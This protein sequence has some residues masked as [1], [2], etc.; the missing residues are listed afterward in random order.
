[1]KAGAWRE[2][3]LPRLR[4]LLAGALLSF[5]FAPFGAWPLAVLCPAWLMWEWQG[6]SARQSAALGFCFGAGTFGAGTWWL[7]ISIHGFGLAPIW[8]ALLLILA[9]V[10]FMAAGYALLGWAVGRLLPA[11]GPW[12]WY[13]GLPGLW[14]LLEWW[15]GWFISGFPWLSLGY[16]QTDTWLAG[17]APVLGV[18]GLSALLLLQSGALLAVLRGGMPARIGAAAALALVWA[19]GLGLGHV[20]WTH[21]AGAAVSV[22]IVQGAIPQDEK[23]QL[24]NREPTMARYH[25]LNEQALGARLIVWPE[26][27]IPELA[28]EIAPFLAGIQASARGHDS[29]VIMGVVR[30]ADNGTDYYNSILALTTGVA[31][32]DKRHLV[33]FAEYFPVPP[34]IRR[35]LRLMSLP[36]SDFTAGADGQG[37]LYA[38]GLRLAPSICYED[39][40]GSAQLA[41]ARKSEVLVNVT[42][43]AW[44][45]RS[46]ARYQHLQIARLRALETGRYLLRAANDGVSAIIGPRGELLQQAPEWQPATLRGTVEPRTGLS[47]YTRVGNWPVVLLALLATAAAATVARRFPGTGSGRPRV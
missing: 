35:W 11:D 21:P 30:L 38:G 45:G 3:W 18:Y 46:P 25:Q 27:A 40:F 8:M 41:L 32:Y 47:P 42:N 28:N 16:S 9:L 12:R 7:Y 20:E 31:F 22:A 10:A 23:W 4:S 13:A 1:V 5:A 14:L 17:Y 6:A 43:D 24:E 34:F 29:D 37:T 44:F 26:S 2:P 19:G 15:R 36:Y 33:P 39:A